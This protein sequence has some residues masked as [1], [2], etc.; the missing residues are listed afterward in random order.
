MGIFPL[1]CKGGMDDVESLISP[2]VYPLTPICHVCLQQCS[3]QYSINFKEFWVSLHVYSVF[4]FLCTSKPALFLKV[5][6][7]NSPN[8]GLSYC[9]V[10]PGVIIIKYLGCIVLRGLTS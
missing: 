5:L 9:L 2:T 1:C 8:P 4:L 10:Q 6:I 3:T 7:D